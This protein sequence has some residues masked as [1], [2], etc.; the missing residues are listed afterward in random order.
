V[1]T[2]TVAKALA[3]PEEHINDF[4]I[5][6]EH[7]TPEEQETVQR[8]CNA[9]TRDVHNMGM[10]GAFEVVGAIGLK[11]A[12]MENPDWKKGA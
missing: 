9:L 5:A 1:M 11:L 6:W 2:D 3:A 10:G 7:M 4:G 8:L 12:K